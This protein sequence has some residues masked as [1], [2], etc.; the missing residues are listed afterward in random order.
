[1]IVSG[2]S[3]AQMSAK[4]FTIDPQPGALAYLGTTC[5]TVYSFSGAQ[6]PANVNPGVAWGANAGDALDKQRPRRGDRRHLQILSP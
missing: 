6:L 5:Q 3:A 4:K 1:M 2:I